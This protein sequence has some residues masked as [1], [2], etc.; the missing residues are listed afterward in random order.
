MA[1][2]NPFRLE[3][4]VPLI[5]FQRSPASR[6]SPIP[7]MVERTSIWFFT[8]RFL[9]ALVAFS[10]YICRSS[11]MLYTES[12]SSP[13]RRSFFFFL[14]LK[15][16]LFKMLLVD[17]LLMI[18]WISASRRE[19]AAICPWDKDIMIVGFSL[20]I[21]VSISVKVLMASKDPEN[22]LIPS[23]ISVGTCP[24]A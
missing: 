7:R 2:P 23:R 4:A 10:A 11:S 1:F 9:D 21:L 22:F 19:R 3:D 13:G 14:V 12:G 24:V 20:A 5:R 15:M 6:L 16:L 17:A 18:S 8:P